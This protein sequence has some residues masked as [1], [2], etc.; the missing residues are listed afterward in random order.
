MV[1]RDRA[2]T[3]MLLDTGLCPWELIAL[4]IGDG[5][6]KAHDGQACRLRPHRLCS[7]V[8]P[9]GR[10]NAELSNLVTRT[11]F[12]IM[13]EPTRPAVGEAQAAS[14]SVGSPGQVARATAATARK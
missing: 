10:A 12:G 13:T 5:D 8:V 9:L 11:A 3:L 2:L 7:V 14:D 1:R 4:N 6:L